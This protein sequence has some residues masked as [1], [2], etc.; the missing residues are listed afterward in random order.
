MGDSFPFGRNPCNSLSGV[1]MVLLIACPCSGAVISNAMTT[2]IRPIGCAMPPP[3]S[4]FLPTDQQVYVF[5][6]AAS[7]AVNDQPKV[8]FYDPGGALVWTGGFTPISTAG[9]YC[10]WPSLSIAGTPRASNLGMYTV[11]GY[12]NDSLVFTVKFWIQHPGLTMDQKVFDFQVIASLYAKRYAPYE[13]KKTL[14]QYD[15]LDLKPWLDRIAQTQ[16]DLDYMEI[17]VQYVAALNDTHCTYRIPSDFAVDLGFRVDAYFDDSGTNYS[18]LIDSITRSLLPAA[19]FPFEVGDEVLSVDGVPVSDLVAKFKPFVSAASWDSGLRRAVSY[20]SLR[21]QS[22]LPKAAL[23]GGS[24]TVEIKRQS[25]SIETYSIPWSMSGTPLTRFEAVPMPKLAGRR[26]LEAD[27]APPYLQPLMRFRNEKDERTLE[28]LNYG[29]LRPVWTLPDGFQQRLGQGSSDSFYTGVMSSRGFKV[30]YLRIP[31]FSPTSATTALRQLETEISFFQDNTDGMVVDVMRNNGGDPCYT[32]E[33]LRRLIPDSWRAMGRQ[34]RPVWD[35]I[36]SLQSSLTLARSLGISQA[37]IDLLQA[38]L[39]DVVAA[40]Q[41]SRALTD[42]VSMCATGLDRTPAAV[43][44]KKRILLL[45]DEFSTSAADAFAAQFQDN[46]R[47]KLFGWRTNGAGGSVI[48]EYPGYYTEGGTSRVVVSM[49]RRPN[50]V[51]TPEYPTAN[52]VENIGVRPDIPVNYMRIGNLRQ[53][54][55]PFVEAFLDAIATEI[56]SSQ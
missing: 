11:K 47:G 30:A 49:Q 54:G 9:S 38:R 14:F 48:D 12:W 45:V 20:I 17:L 16:D 37:T 29:S 25:G 18:V 51:T 24:A 27:D 8:E 50:P 7:A 10:F 36:V 26:A 35:D 52:Y 31:N 13:W 6:R 44:Y 41:A 4:T 56:E 28:I 46:K 55:K 53:N 5:F 15:A 42:P 40:Y 19:T 21:S 34:L 39:N 43:V 2:T 32:E 3:V 33:V 23:V 1:L 22:A